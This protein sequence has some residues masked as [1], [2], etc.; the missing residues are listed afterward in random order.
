VE[1]P[2]ERSVEELIAEAEGAAVGRISAGQFVASLDWSLPRIA[3][4]GGE[5]AP[6]STLMIADALD[7]LGASGADLSPTAARALAA[8]AAV[9]AREGHDPE[10]VGKVH[11]LLVSSRLA[12]AGPA[13]EPRPRAVT[14]GRRDDG[15]ATVPTE[16]PLPTD[17]ALDPEIARAAARLA[18]KRSAY[19]SLGLLGLG[20]AVAICLVAGVLG[21]LWLDGRFGTSP[22]LTGLGT[23]VGLVLAYLVFREMLRQSRA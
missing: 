17:P 22:L 2:V 10:S 9:A 8:A 7:R 6:Q 23:I 3:Q 20:W 13:P 19:Q 12:P 21:G 18:P 5:Y 15:D 11:N 1:G 16:D 14:Y 4:R